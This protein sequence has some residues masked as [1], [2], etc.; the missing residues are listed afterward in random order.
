MKTNTPMLPSIKQERRQTFITRSIMALMFI[1]MMIVPAAASD[2]Q[3]NATSVIEK[4]V[5]PMVKII[6]IPGG[7][8]YAIVGGIKYAMA[9]AEGEG[10]AMHKAINMIVAGIA[11]VAIAAVISTFPW[12]ELL[13]GM[14]K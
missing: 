6:A 7:V 13:S 2:A 5:I 4:I 8:I 3:A 10:P 1:A 11:I 12:T 14:S 9:H